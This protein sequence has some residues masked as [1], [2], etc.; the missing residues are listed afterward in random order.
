MTR[1]KRK[2]PRPRISKYESPPRVPP[3]R[4]LG[5]AMKNA[6]NG[7]SIDDIVNL[8]VELS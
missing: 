1:I 8:I 3:N 4:G 7:Y 6:S 5:I 2:K